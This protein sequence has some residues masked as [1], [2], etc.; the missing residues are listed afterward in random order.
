MSTKHGE[1]RRRETDDIAPRVPT[2]RP[3]SAAARLLCN[4]RPEGARSLPG[5]LVP[6]ETDLLLSAP[7]NFVKLVA[8]SLHAHSF[9]D[10]LGACVLDVHVEAQAANVAGGAGPG[11]D[12]FVQAA[13]DAHAA[14]FVGNEDALDP[15]EP[16]VAPVAPFSGDQ[17]LAD[18]SLPAFGHV[19]NAAGRIRQQVGD[20]G[21]NRFRIELPLLG[22]HRHRNIIGGDGISIGRDGLTNIDYAHERSS[23]LSQPD[24][25]R[26]GFPHWYGSVAVEV[27]MIQE[28][29]NKRVTVMGLGRF[30][31]G[32]GVTRWL[33]DNGARVLVTDQATPDLLKKAL[34]RIKD[35]GVELR[36]GEHRESDFRDTDL[37][38]VS[39][40]VPD[41]NEYIAAARNAGVTITT[42]INLFVK[43]CP[44]RT[45]GITGSVGKST[46]T[47]MIG[48]LLERTKPGRR[49]WVGG[50]LGVSLLDKLAQIK[51]DDFVVLEL[52]SFQLARTAA[53][54]WS[55]NIAVITNI[56]PNH[57]DWHGDY[58][59]YIA[60]KLEIA[61]FQDL[62]RDAL[63][64][65][66]H[67]NLCEQL[68]HVSFATVKPWRYGLDEAVKPVA[69]R[70]QLR[71]V[72][73][74][75]RLAIPG[76]HNREN[77]A[78]ALTVS[79]V[80][81]IEPEHA[82]AALATFEGLPH[83]LQRIAVRKGVTFYNDSKCTTPAAAITAMNAIDSPL[84]IIMGG[85]DKGS[86]LTPAAELAA[87]R[88]RF[89][90][91]IGKT[92]PKIVEAVR[93][94][95]GAAEL[96]ESL[97]D[98]VRACRQAAHPGDAVLLSPA[99]ASW[100]MFPDYRV[101]GDEFTR[102]ADE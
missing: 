59:A 81:N 61:R 15:P 10:P 89:T 72:W 74:N 58:A 93:A 50:N 3:Q 73:P 90:A 12:V 56:S 17:H 75:L 68:E 83:R 28:W 62:K 70:G 39:P 24:R 94:A 55:P 32:V 92:G 2:G 52:S 64:I 91:C 43:H 102:L 63:I 30:G 16:A 18:H 29:K 80:L 1:Q 33:V 36:L 95:G 85:Y 35:L 21:A 13:V 78:A 37:V 48:H 53:A 42:E 71:H 49:I 67:Q 45:I 20:A 4:P 100:D 5:T 31:G 77:A 40:A 14:G 41:S 65:G 79:Y 66:D 101:R 87:R 69:S 46:T 84:L 82:T 26:S 88:A 47:A 8:R 22:L 6:Q 44:A 11:L 25:S 99:C 27:S 97:A 23:R 38:V 57:L 34:D 54:H 9:V 51:A 98:A 86:D 76:R 60:A 7:I 96:Y 19:V